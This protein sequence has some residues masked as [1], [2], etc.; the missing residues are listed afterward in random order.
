MPEA[1]E[2][3]DEVVEMVNHGRLLLALILSYLE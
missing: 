1:C 3:G 2:E